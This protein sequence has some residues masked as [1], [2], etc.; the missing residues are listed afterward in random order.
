MTR[1]CPFSNGRVT[2]SPMTTLEQKVRAR[3]SLPPPE[4]RRALRVGA[5]L[6]Q[7]DIATE[8]H[9]HRETVS[10]WERG[11]RAPQGQHLVAYLEVLSD[12]RRLA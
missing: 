4:V 12:L 3:R 1:R 7:Q 11:E 2:V 6:S 5:G 9:V 8:V 10:R